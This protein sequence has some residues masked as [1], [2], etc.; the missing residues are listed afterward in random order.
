[1]SHTLSWRLIFDLTEEWPK[2]RES[3]ERRNPHTVQLHP[4]KQTASINY[5]IICIHMIRDYQ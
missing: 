2:K 5:T 3:L 4:H 1:M